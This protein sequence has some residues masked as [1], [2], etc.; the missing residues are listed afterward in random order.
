[1]PKQ[2]MSS[3]Q[4]NFPADVLTMVNFVAKALNTNRSDVIRECV[5]RELPCI[6]ENDVADQQARDHELESHYLKITLVDSPVFPE[7]P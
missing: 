6:I 5:R 3:V 1:L 4:I 7:N 2:S